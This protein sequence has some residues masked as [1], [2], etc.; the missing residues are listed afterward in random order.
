MY[1]S[2]IP[3]TFSRPQGRN[4]CGFFRLFLVDWLQHTLESALWSANVVAVY[5]FF[6]VRLVRFK[7]AQSCPSCAFY[8]I[9]FVPL[10][11][12]WLLAFSAPSSIEDG[13][14]KLAM[15]CAFCGS[16]SHLAA[17]YQCFYEEGEW[18]II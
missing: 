7:H 18:C 14:E 8:V 9:G 10:R 6:A 5:F 11:R 3:R 17:G 4:E 13:Q 2:L 12:R 16:L 15:I 1:R